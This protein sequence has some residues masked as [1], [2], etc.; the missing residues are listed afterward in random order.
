MNNKLHWHIK[1]KTYKK[2]RCSSISTIIFFTF[3]DTALSTIINPAFSTIN[4]SIAF[5][6]LIEF[7]A[8]IETNFKSLNF[9]ENTNIHHVLFV[10]SFF[11]EYQFIVLF[12]FSFFQ[13][14]EYGFRG[15]RYAFCNIVFAK[16]NKL[17]N[18]YVDLKCMMFLINHKFFKINASDVEIQKMN[19]FMTIKRINIATH[20]INKYINIDFYLFTSINKV[21]HLKREFHFVNDFKTNM[22]IGIDIM[23]IENMI[24]NFS[25]KKSPL[26]N[27][28]TKTISYWMFPS[29]SFHWSINQVKWSIFNVIK[30]V[31]P[32]NNRQMIDIKNNKNKFFKLSK[33]HNLLFEFQKQNDFQ[34]YVHIIDH[35]LFFIQVFNFINV[36]I[37]FNW[38]IWLRDVCEYEMK[39]C[40][41]TI[42][43]KTELTAA[44]FKK[45]KIE[46]FKKTMRTL[47]A[48]ATVATV[49]H[50]FSTIT[51]PTEVK[52]DNG[53]MIYEPQTDVSIIE[54]IT[55]KN[56]C[57]EKIMKTWWTYWKKCE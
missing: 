4:K 14:K 10:K 22:L 19:S 52:L 6:F 28:K 35:I 20:Q 5:P 37:I 32:P 13:P 46:W 57:Y 47:L 9:I 12:T 33:N 51:N 1:L 44:P 55:K 15:W 25:N 36:F 26:L 17:Q 45:T 30:T 31:I 11:E 43:K 42:A 7:S 39:G 2:P 53:I 27:I 18:V 54:T 40:H 29:I 16:Q 34:I 24:F 8:D 3:S 50:V 38:N 48:T 56:P 41:L 49:M 21:A 23:I